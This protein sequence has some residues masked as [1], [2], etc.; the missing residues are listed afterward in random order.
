MISGMH[1]TWAQTSDMDRSVAFYRD[2]LGLTPGM[3]SA[4]W[5]EFHVGENKIALHPVLSGHEGPVGKAGC[6]WYLSF[7]TDDLKLLRQ[8]L[9]DAGARITDDYHDVPTGVVLTFEDPDGNP[10]QAIQLGAKRADLD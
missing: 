1:T 3:L 8:T 6:G 2:V 5:S 4:Y 9:Q 10:M 7:I